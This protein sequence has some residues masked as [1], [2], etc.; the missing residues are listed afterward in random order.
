MIYQ[1]SSFFLDNID[2]VSSH[3]IVTNGMVNTYLTLPYLGKLNL[4]YLPYLI[5]LLARSV[6]YLFV[7]PLARIREFFTFWGG[8]GKKGGRIDG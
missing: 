3:W 1:S 4:P 5:T 2:N 8:R 7:N 6:P